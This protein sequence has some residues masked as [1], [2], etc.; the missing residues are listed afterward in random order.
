MIASVQ[1]IL[2]SLE[3]ANT[4]L[5]WI[6]ISVEFLEFYILYMQNSKAKVNLQNSA[7][8]KNFQILKFVK[9]LKKI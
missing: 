8:N 3:F 1:C 4:T 7:F 5:I 9:F 6:V 2:I